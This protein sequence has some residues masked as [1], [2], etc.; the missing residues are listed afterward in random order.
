MQAV[1]LTAPEAEHGEG[2]VWWPAWGGLVWVDMLAGDVLRSEAGAAA[3]RWHVGAVAAALRPWGPTGAI[4]ALED[5]LATAAAFGDSPEPLIDLLDDPEVRLNEGGCD[6]DGAFWVGSMRYDAGTG[7]GRLYRIDR[8][9]SVSEMASDVSVSNG[10]AWGM[11]GRG[12]YADS[13]TRR[14]DV[15]EADGFGERR[16][17]V[18]LHDTPGHPD[19][20]CVDAEGGV[21]VAVWQG[22]AVHRY[23]PDGRLSAVVELPVAQVTSCTFGGPDL[24][25]LYVTTSRH[26][27]RDPAPG[28]GAVF[29]A[30]VGVKGLPA[31]G[32]AG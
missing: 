25:L 9:G 17:F 13:P 6:L 1:Q 30:D 2:A 16:P 29:V 19:G 31:L 28:A 12:Y 20:L 4:L 11:D 3:E 23:D 27:E 18:Q 14:I 10:I 26:D 22:A 7:G 32:W 15:F 24:D 5:G 21:W 8:Q